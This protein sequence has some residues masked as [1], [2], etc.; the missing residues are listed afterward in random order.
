MH[1][2]MRQKNRDKPSMEDT[3]YRQAEYDRCSRYE[4]VRCREAEYEI[5]QF[6]VKGRL[7]SGVCV[8]SQSP[9]QAETTDEV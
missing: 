5:C 6:V 4:F 1:D 9:E 2:S 7:M 3:D 8:R